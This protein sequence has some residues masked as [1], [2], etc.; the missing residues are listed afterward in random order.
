V[1]TPSFTHAQILNEMHS[2]DAAGCSLPRSGINRWCS[3]H[4]NKARRYGHPAAG[5]L[6]PNRWATERAQVRALLGA[7]VDHPGLQQVLAMLSAWMAKGSANES[8]YPGAEEVARLSRHGVSALDILVEVCAFWCWLQV[9]PR[10]LPQGGAD[11]ARAV[12]FALSRAV[13]HLAPRPQRVA[14][15]SQTSYSRKARSSAL[16]HIGRH[17]RQTLAPFLVNVSHHVEPP[18]AKAARAAEAMKAPFFR[19]F[20]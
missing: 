10:S 12:D 11:G 5:P 6:R 19:P 18:E 20:L 2:C 1:P 14:W 7:N 4:L 3:D 15:P 8:S 9:N 16:A 17:L 13:F